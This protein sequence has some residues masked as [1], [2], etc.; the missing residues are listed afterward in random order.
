VRASSTAS[1]IAD[2]VVDLVH[3]Q[4]LENPDP[5]QR[6]VDGRHPRHRPALACSARSWSMRSRWAVTP[7]TRQAA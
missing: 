7:S 5:Q 2:R 1:V 3:P 6:A 4:Q